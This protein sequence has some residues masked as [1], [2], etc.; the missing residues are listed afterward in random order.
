ML[1]EEGSYLTFVDP[2]DPNPKVFKILRVHNAVV[3]DQED[4]KGDVYQQ[5]RS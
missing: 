2:E 5:Y 4:I 1:Y 3:E